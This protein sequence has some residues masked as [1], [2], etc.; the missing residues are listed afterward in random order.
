MNMIALVDNIGGLGANGK[1]LYKVKEDMMYFKQRTENKVVVMGRNTF[2]SLPNGA[3]PN[4]TN[5]VL[6][7]DKNFAP[8]GVKVVHNYQDL[9]KEL[10]N[11]PSDDIFIIGGA[12]LYA[13]LM[14][15]CDVLYINRLNTAEYKRGDIDTFFPRFDA[16]KTIASEWDMVERHMIHVQYQI[17][18][19]G[20]T[21]FAK[22]TFFVFR[23]HEA[24]MK[25]MQDA[26]Q[27]AM[28]SAT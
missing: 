16:Y 8:D 2:D 5:I 13:E 1:L 24:L 21:G 17:V 6:S 15:K 12:S 27:I 3:L 14:N 20:N 23:K 28:Q 22:L 11:Y 10:E 7:S 19:T 26:S 18:A 4:R 9:M 25:A